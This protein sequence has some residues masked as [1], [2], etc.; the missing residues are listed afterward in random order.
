MDA[1]KTGIG[2]VADGFADGDFSVC[3]FVR[4]T[5]IDALENL[6]FRQAGVF[7]TGDLITTKGRKALKATVEDSFNGGVGETNQTE[8]HR[9]AT[10]G[11]EPIGPGEFENLGL[12]V[13]RTE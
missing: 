11:I 3:L 8:H 9:I 5:L 1:D 4:H 10:Y 7:Q 6:F 12:G 2:V 13:T